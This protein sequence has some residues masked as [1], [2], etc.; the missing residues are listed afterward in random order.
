[1][2]T[3]APRKA[4]VITSSSATCSTQVGVA[5]RTYR[6]KTSQPK[7]TVRTTRDTPVS[8]LQT[9]AMPFSNAS[10]DRTNSGRFWSVCRSF[11]L[12][13]PKSYAQ[14]EIE[15]GVTELRSVLLRCLDE[16]DQRPDRFI[17]RQIG[18]VNR[19]PC[20]RSRSRRCRRPS[21]FRDLRFHAR[22]KAP[23]ASLH[24]RQPPRSQPPSSRPRGR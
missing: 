16:F 13:F 18:L 3:A 6:P 19:R 21:P 15:L 4:I 9:A 23:A 24:S 11:I 1:M 5:F 7:I 8:S 20:R 2:P 22:P 10:I 14:P 12:V 17:L